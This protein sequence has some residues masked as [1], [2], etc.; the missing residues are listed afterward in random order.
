MINTYKIFLRFILIFCAATLFVPS[1]LAVE[2]KSDWSLNLKDVDIRA[3]VEQV[4]SITG[5]NFV[6]DPQVKGKITVIATTPMTIDAVNELFLTVLRV[7]GYAAVPSGSVTRIV[8]QGTVKLGAAEGKNQEIITRVVR[9]K[10]A[11]VDD[12]IKLLRP[13]VSSN[14]YVEGSVFSNSLIISD[15]A[16]NLHNITDAL[17][18][19]DHSNDND[20]EIISLTQAWVGNIVPLIESLAPMQLAENGKNRNRLRVVADEHSN[21]IIVKGDK[22]DRIKIRKLVEKLDQHSAN[23]VNIQMIRLHYADAKQVASMLRGIVSGE[24]KSAGGSE[25]GYPQTAGMTQEETANRNTLASLF[26]A[27]P[28]AA[29]VPGKPVAEEGEDI[30]TAHSFIQADV[31]LNAIIVKAEPNVMS[32]IRSLVKQLDVRR[33]EVL[34]EAAIV[35]VNSGQSDQVGVQVAGGQLARSIHSGETDFTPT[36]SGVDLNGML[37][38]LNSPQAA[39]FAGGQGAAIALGVG[40]KFDVLLQALANTTGANLLSTPSV[41]TLDNEEAK[42]VVGQNVP[43]ITGSYSTLNSG[44]TNPFT[45][46]ER[47]DVGITLKVVPQIQEGNVVRLTISQEVSSV[48]TASNGGAVTGAVDLVTNKRSIETRVLADDGETIVLGGLIQDDSTKNVSKVPILG[49]IPLIGLLFSSH[50][51]SNSKSNLLV[52]LRPTIINS[53]EKMASVAQTHYDRAN[54]LVRELDMSGSRPLNAP[55]ASPEAVFNPSPKT[56]PWLA[57]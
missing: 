2:K 40:N 18:E 14:G 38:K 48:A 24:K 21:S 45:T 35:E 12:A 5:E 33:P 7:N 31:A 50:E 20:V 52:F 47:Q 25:P 42:M 51:Q 29:A 36:G 1:S 16:D 9:V 44:V 8:P 30:T 46:V 13:L 15:Y 4:S 6:I 43:F 23:G 19:L 32:E 17:A 10:N 49:D 53:H 22:A 37:T 34:I 11:S 39:A 26:S 57:K 3:F 55:S 56:L 54:D 27:A 41:T 28:A